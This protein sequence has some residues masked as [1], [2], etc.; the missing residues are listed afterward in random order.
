LIITRAPALHPGDIQLAT[1][2]AVPNNSP[3]MK[4]R[5]CICSS[6]KGSRNLPSQ[7]SGGDLDGDLYQII[8]DHKARPKKVLAPAD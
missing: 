1:A 7:L 5:N 4:L 8:F 3:L 6:Q 2:I